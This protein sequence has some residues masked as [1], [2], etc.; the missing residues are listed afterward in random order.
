MKL[1]LKVALFVF[2]F[3]L[4][5]VGAN[6]ANAQTYKEQRKANRE[7]RKD[8]RDA[9]KDYRK[10]IRKG[11]NFRDARKDYRKDIR[12]A[13]KDYRKRTGSSY[14]NRYYRNGRWYYRR[15]H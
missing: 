6:S 2:A 11:K 10:D 14:R 4:F 13:R 15:S 9:R 3:G 12:D 5:F 7:Y 8:V 1:I